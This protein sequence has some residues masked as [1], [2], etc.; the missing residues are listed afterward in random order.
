MVAGQIV[1][2]GIRNLDVVGATTILAC[3]VQGWVLELLCH[4]AV[5]CGLFVLD[6]LDAY[7]LCLCLL[8]PYLRGEPVE[9][10]YSFRV[11]TARG[12]VRTLDLS[13]VLIQWGQRDATLLFVV[14]VTARVRAE[15]DQKRALQQQIELNDL[16]SRFISVA[17]HEFRTPLA[18]IHGSVELLSHY[19]ARMS[20]EQK[21]LTLQKIDDAVARMAHLAPTDERSG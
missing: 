8:L 17:S 19:E 18:T 10:N 6:A 12:E 1:R 9:E 11:I 21:R 5:V 15:A 16:K 3:T 7:T 4:K 20:T 13:A 14:D 2:L